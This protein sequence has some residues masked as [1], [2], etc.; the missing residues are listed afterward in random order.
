MALY[1]NNTTGFLGEFASNPGAGYTAIST[2]PTNTIAARVAWWRGLDTH[3]QSSSW[4]PSEYRTPQDPAEAVLSLQ[5]SSSGAFIAADATGAVTDNYLGA[6]TTVK[7]FRGSTDVTIS[8]GWALSKVDVDCVSTLT[9]SGGVYTLAITNIPLLATTTGYVRI[10]ATRSGSTTQTRDFNFLKAIRGANGTS[11]VDGVR[12]SR[13]LLV[14]N[15]TGTWSDQEAWQGIVTQ[16]GTAP[17]LSDLVTIAKTDGTAATSKFYAGGG[18]GTTTWGTWTTP[19]AYINGS[20]LVTGSV[21][22]NQIA[23][24]SI[25]AGKMVAGTIT[26]ASGIIA[27]AAI[28]N[29]KIADL[30]A[31][32]INTGTLNGTNVTVTNLSAS[33]ITGGT[34]SVDRIAANS[35]NGSKIGTGSSGLNTYNIIKQA[36]SR[37]VGASVS[38][39]A[40][41]GSGPR[42]VTIW[43]A[44]TLSWNS[45]IGWGYVQ[46]QNSIA[47]YRNDTFINSEEFKIRIK[48]NST[49]LFEQLVYI[50]G[51]CPIYLVTGHY[52]DDMT[53]DLIQTNV[54]YSCEVYIS[55]NVT[56]L[57]LAYSCLE[58]RR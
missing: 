50:A 13:Q 44:P 18:N 4:H 30:S 38:G 21:G 49:I 7:V 31:S 19:T 15:S 28:T 45:Q 20:L 47:V 5:F 53:E 51:N 34:L 2:M 37:G 12:G 48:R 46:V 41:A 27:D 24:N 9:L 58:L 36:V 8:E 17:V 57:A 32:K 42:W 23:A 29:A 11:G 35:I 1:R 22:A 3:G 26:A 54:T 33:N 40:P 6:T 56:G 43:T 10:T 39:Y 14:T 25:T 52:V 55:G 16:T